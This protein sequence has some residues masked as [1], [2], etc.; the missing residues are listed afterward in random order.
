M[1]ENETRPLAQKYKTQLKMEKRLEFKT[2]SSEITRG[3]CKRI[4]QDI[5]IGMYLGEG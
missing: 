4:L 2:Q 1:Q 5:S 3:K